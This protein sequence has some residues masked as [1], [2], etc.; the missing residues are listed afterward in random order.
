MA[1]G[2]KGLMNVQFAIKDET[3]YVLEVNPRASRTVPFVSKAIGRPLAK[4]AAM[5]M[6]GLKLTDPLRINFTEEIIPTH[7]SLK[8]RRLPL[9]K[10]P[11]HR[12]SA[13]T[14]NEIDR[15][16]HGHRRRFWAGLREVADGRAAAACPLTGNVFISV[17]DA[18]KKAVPD[19]ARGLQALG[20]WVYST[21][22]TAY[23]TRRPPA[24]RSS[25]CTR[26][27]KAAPMSSTC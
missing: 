14:R 15:R 22:G 27:M 13:R 12:Y 6:S 9:R 7:Y 18:D 20:F 21:S 2:V 4:Y 16:S 1:L 8:E 24:C 25:V 26:S 23:H 3:V 5:I 10:I 17:R 19:L 11:R